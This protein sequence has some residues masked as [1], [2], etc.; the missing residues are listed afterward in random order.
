MGSLQASDSRQYLANIT[1][2]DAELKSTK[3]PLGAAQEKIRVLE[4]L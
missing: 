4:G 2:L 3:A 1:R